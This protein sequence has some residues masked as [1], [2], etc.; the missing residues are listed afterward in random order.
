MGEDVTK[1]IEKVV[2]YFKKSA[3]QN[4][5]YAAYQLGKIYLSGAYFQKDIESALRYF[6]ISVAKG[7]Q[8]AEYAL[9]KLYLQ[10]KD[11]PRDIEKAMEYLTA[12]ANQ[13][14]LYAK[15]L[16][17]HLDMFRDPSVFMVA[18][19]LLHR[20]E[21][22]FR[23]DYRKANGGSPYHIDRKR[24]RKLAE[25]KQAQGHKQ[26]DHEPVQQLY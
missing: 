24:R 9:G 14:N 17:E 2:Y 1:N 12:S 11:V 4:N 20:L 22:L 23:E 16:L 6:E 13:G 7:N 10:G 3:E 18:T 8:Y 19:R 21:D 5:E 15:F 25:K 26:D